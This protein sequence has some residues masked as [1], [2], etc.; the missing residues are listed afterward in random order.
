MS[1][2][3][4][5]RLM[6]ALDGPMIVVTASDGPRIAGCLVGFNGQS[7]IDPLHYVVYLSKLNHTYRVARRATHLMVHFLASDQLD[8]ARHFGELTGDETA[9]F[10]GVRWKPGP[11]GST[12]RLTEC[13]SHL[14]GRIARRHQGDG[15]HGAFVLE[16]LSTRTAR[17]FRPLRYR[18]VRDLDPG[19]PPDEK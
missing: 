11:D 10:D 6:A 16:P 8:L 17:D 18:H 3:S 13:R 7:S 14:W 4:F 12:P 2:S 9:K 1:E 15:D 5:T 19:H